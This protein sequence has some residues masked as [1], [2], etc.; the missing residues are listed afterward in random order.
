MDIIVLDENFTPIERLK[1]VNTLIWERRAA[2]PGIFE[3]HCGVSDFPVLHAGHYLYRSDREELGVIYEADTSRNEAGAQTCYAKGYFAEQML[4]DRV[5]DRT[6]SMSGTREDIARQLVTDFFISA[7]GYEGRSV[8]RIELGAKLNVDSDETTMQATG[9]PVGDVISAMEAERGMAHRLLYDWE[10]D[11]L[12]FS[13]YKGAD[14]GAIFSDEWGNVITAAYHRDRTDAPNVIFVAGAG[15]GLDRKIYMIDL[16]ESK[17]KYAREMYVDAR[18]IQQ[19]W[20]TTDEETGETKTYFYDDTTYGQLLEARGLQKVEGHKEL[21]SFSLNVNPKANLRYREDYDVG[22]WATVRIT[23][24]KGHRISVLRQITAVREVYQDGQ[25]KLSVT[26]GNTGPVSLKEYFTA[27]AQVNVSSTT[28]GVGDL[29]QLDTEEKGSLV[30]AINEVAKKTGTDSRIGDLKDLKTENSDTIVDAINELDDEIG[31]TDD[32]DVDPPPEEEIPPDE[33]QAPKDLTAAINAIQKQIGKLSDLSTEAKNNLVAAINESASTGGGE[34]GGGTCGEDERIGD[35]SQLKTSSKGTIVDA[36]NETYNMAIP[37]NLGVVLA[38][39]PNASLPSGA[40]ESN[41]FGTGTIDASSAYSINTATI[42]GSAVESGPVNFSTYKAN[43]CAQGDKVITMVHG[44]PLYGFYGFGETIVKSSN[45][46]YYVPKSLRGARICVD[47]K[48]T[49]SS[50]EHDIR[51]VIGCDLVN[52]YPITDNN[53]NYV[54]YVPKPE[55]LPAN[56]LG[57]SELIGQEAARSQYLY[58]PFIPVVA[59]KNSTKVIIGIEP[60]ENIFQVALY[61]YAAAMFTV[62]GELRGTTGFARS[63]EFAGWAHVGL[64]AGTESL[65]FKK[66]L[67]TVHR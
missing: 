18:D 28:A 58:T 32:L 40:T 31:D 56:V 55:G 46:N 45:K 3:V 63:L 67:S 20:E 48:L 41:F 49:L 51:C 17:D 30:K 36:L 22:D 10:R 9:K 7:D 33:Q 8:S 47:V 1:T 53:K 66:W 11:K 19:S 14:R 52:G 35:M 61:E 57:K 29:S 6:W 44:M 62:S 27:S 4:A 2:T 5:V 16:R 26:F 42:S 39:C 38:G 21:E 65:T 60:G 59:N 50:E 43:F 12:V 37:K 64:A 34:G 23:L 25:E 24:H 13:Q 54:A 15:E